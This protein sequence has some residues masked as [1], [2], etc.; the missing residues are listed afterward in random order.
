VTGRI[1]LNRLVEVLSTNPAKI[2][3]LYPRKGVV[4]PGSDAD[5]VIVDFE[6]SFKIKATSLH[7]GVDWSPYEGK[8][9]FG[10]VHA[11]LLRGRFVVH[12]GELKVSKG[13]GQYLDRRLPAKEGDMHGA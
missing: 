5:L 4:Q 13:Y 2:F 8:D 12:D 1:S 7:G 9:V 3:G 6:H 11:T 10:R